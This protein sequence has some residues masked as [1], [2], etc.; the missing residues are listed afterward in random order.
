[1][2]YGAA[3]REAARHGGPA[4][5]AVAPPSTTRPC[6]PNLPPLT[7]RP[8]PPAA[9]CRSLANLL[10]VLRRRLTVLKDEPHT[11]EDLAHYQRVLD[12]V[13]ARWRDEEG[14]FAGRLAA[15]D[16]KTAQMCSRLFNECFGK[17]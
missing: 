2:S 4:A 11:T 16:P 15:A 14:T 9:A 17:L 12:D 7:T 5:A 3:S 6:P 1:M 8:C 13:D 10:S